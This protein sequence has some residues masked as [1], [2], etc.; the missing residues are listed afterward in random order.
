[1]PGI[2]AL[3]SAALYGKGVFTTIAIRQGEPF[4]WEKH[5]RRLTA[6][7]AKL[8]IDLSA[9]NE[10]KTLASLMQTIGTVLECRARVTFFDESSSPIWPSSGE[11][12]TSLQI[13]IGERRSVP[14]QVRLTVSPYRINSTS[15]LAGVKSCNYLEHLAAFENA[16]SHGF[17]EAVRMNE[18]G[19]IASACMAN[20]FWLKAGRLYTPSLST[21]CLPG[22]MREYILENL[23]CEEA[24]SEIDALDGAEQIFLTSAGIGVVAVAEING[25][26]LAF[27][28]HRILN[29]L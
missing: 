3:S 27:N 16:M 15:P 18:N 9:H 5:W 7:A 8:S 14:E 2:N 26:E 11:A 24:E 28:D 23:E 29:L 1:M 20:I 13:I 21:G 17:D 4:L 19:H 12:K 10:S 25:R 6:N 22:T